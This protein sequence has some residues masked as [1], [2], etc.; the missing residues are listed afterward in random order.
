MKREDKVRR[1]LRALRQAKRSARTAKV[2]PV[3]AL[4]PAL[5]NAVATARAAYELCATKTEDAKVAVAVRNASASLL[6]SFDLKQ[7]PRLGDRLRL[8]W[9]AAMPNAQANLLEECARVL[10]DAVG[11]ADEA[12]SD[13][14]RLA[15]AEAYSLFTAVGDEAAWQGSQRGVAFLSFAR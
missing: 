2:E 15:S 7:S 12:T 9:L 4:P 8:E 5:A 10:S 11:M 14:I 13:R 6:S 1:K 3:S